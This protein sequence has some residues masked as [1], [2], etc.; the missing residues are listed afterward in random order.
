MIRAGILITGTEVLSGAVS[1]RN[2]PWLSQRL[3]ELGVEV[4]QIVIVGDRPHDLTV[5][6]TAMREQQ[7]DLVLTSGGLGPTADDLTVATIAQHLSLP[8]VLDEQLQ[9]RIA[10]IVSA[11]A[12]RSG[13]SQEAFDA[14]NAKQATIPAGALVLEPVGTAPG[15]V[16]APGGGAS[17][18]QP[19]I[20]VL[21]GPP[22]ELQPMWR[23]AAH[24]PP[25]RELL[26]R[27]GSHTLHTMRL[28]GVPESELAQSLRDAE[29][30]GLAL[31]E[32]EIT[33]C[34]HRGELE[35]TTRVPDGSAD[36]YASFARFLADRHG[37]A[38]FST[39]GASVDERVAALLRR[40][41]KLAVAESCTGGMLAAR[42][43]DL[44]GSSEYMLGGVVA[45][46]NAVKI[47]A[48]G[49][50][51]ELI[52]THGAVSQQVASALASGVRARLDADVG[53][54]VTGVAGPGG[55]TQEKPV[56][57]VWLAVAGPREGTQTRCVRLPGGRPEIR[58]RAVTV[59]MHMLRVALEA[60]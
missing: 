37:R 29:R 6:L 12:R 9:Q 51:A 10:S 56:G 33:T 1:D 35:I 16:I 40:S 48:V 45:Y 20:V 36:A 54:G 21:P 46:D 26:A 34:Q 19:L 57:L 43:T 27:A 14:G 49:V 25:L 52:E 42:I 2:G 39:D 44:P 59:A 50:H 15:L 38:L 58:E 17:P 22:R 30:S 55:G 3:G 31:S 4:T 28:F 5:A 47:N 18:P 32:L 60:A 7:L 24:T 23:S 13:R 41:H 53:V 8:L 11:L